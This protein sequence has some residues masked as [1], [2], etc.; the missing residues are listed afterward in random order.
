MKGWLLEKHGFGLANAEGFG[1]LYFYSLCIPF[2]YFAELY[3]DGP[4]RLISNDIF[5][6]FQHKKEN[7]NLNNL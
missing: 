1:L 7:E 6:M 5:K 4:A 3:I 2:S